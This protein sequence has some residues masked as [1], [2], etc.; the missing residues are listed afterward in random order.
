[1]RGVSW[2]EARRPE[3]CVVNVRCT[4]TAGSC[5][6]RVGAGDGHRN[7]TRE[8]RRGKNAWEFGEGG[9]AE[10]QQFEAERETWGLSL[11]TRQGQTAATPRLRAQVLGKY[12]PLTSTVFSMGPKPTVWCHDWV[13]LGWTAHQIGRRQRTYATSP[14]GFSRMRSVTRHFQ[15]EPQTSR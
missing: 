12:V 10:Q 2:G 11:R 1:M 6:I 9:L 14:L 4:P 13:Q 8:Q 15:V 7:A 5:Q 3:R